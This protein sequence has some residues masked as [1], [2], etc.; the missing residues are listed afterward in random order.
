M[1]TSLDEQFL[2]DVASAARALSI[3]RTKVFELLNAG[4]SAFGHDRPP[5]AHSP[6][7]HQ[8]IRHTPAGVEVSSRTRRDGLPKRPSPQ[9][10]RQSRIQSDRITTDRSG[11]R[12]RLGS[13]RGYR[14]SGSNTNA[15]RIIPRSPNCKKHVGVLNE[16]RNAMECVVNQLVAIVDTREY[17][18]LQN[19][20]VADTR[21]VCPVWA[22]WEGDRRGILPHSEADAAVLLAT[23]LTT[24]RNTVGV[25]AHMPTLVVCSTRLACSH[26]SWASQLGLG[27]ERAGKSATDSDLCGSGVEGLHPLRV[28]KRRSRGR[29]APGSLRKRPGGA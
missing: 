25:R 28:W 2:Y 5:P 21:R 14:S 22:S 24:Y 29:H 4:E 1:S 26:S 20:R 19:R 17:L 12:R 11:E 3:G 27:R 7:R 23:L 15:G 6:R 13:R 9:N 10:R 16:H 18:E 8:R